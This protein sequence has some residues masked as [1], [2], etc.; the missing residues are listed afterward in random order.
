[1]ESRNSSNGYKILKVLRVYFSPS[2][3]MKCLKHFGMVECDPAS[4]PLIIGCKLSKE[5]DWPSVDA[6]YYRSMIGNLLCLTTSPPD[7]IHEVGMV[8]RFQCCPKNSNVLTIKQIFRYIKGTIHY[9]LYYAKRKKIDLIKYTNAD[10]AWSIDER[11]ITS[12][13]AFFLGEC[14]VAWSS[15]K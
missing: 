11:K 12:G 4:T 15:R 8:V 10:W 1:M 5:D 7:I 3:W 6:T 13:N 2:T 14:L 9:R